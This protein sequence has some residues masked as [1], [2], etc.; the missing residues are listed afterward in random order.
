MMFDSTLIGLNESVWYLNFMIPL[1]RSLLMMVGTYI[2]MI[3]SY[4]D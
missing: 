3:Y 2:H 4:V 1:V